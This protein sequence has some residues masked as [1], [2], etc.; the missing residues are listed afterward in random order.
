MSVLVI[1]S[2][3]YLGE[4]VVDELLSQGYDVVGFDLRAAE[5]R[6][7]RE[8]EGYAFERGDMTS[9][10]DVSDAIT[11]H[12]VDAAVQLAYYGTPENGLLDSAEQEPY[13]ASNT[14]VTGFNNV[15]ECARQFDLDALVWASSTVVYGPPSYYDEL[16]IETVDEESPTNPTSLYGA[17]K[18]HNEYV[19]EMYRR[20][21]G[22]D[23]AGIR[24]P[25]IYGPRRYPGAQPFIV[26]MFDTVAEG[27]RIDI[28]DGDTTWDLL[29]ERD[30]GP[31]LASVL[32]AGAYEQS[33]YNVYGHTVTVREL[34]SLALKFAPDDADV[35][36]DDGDAA[37]L[38]APLDDSRFRTEF[39]YRPRYDAESAVEDYLNTIA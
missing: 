19:A 5:D 35:S 22:L 23:V 39:E 15:L 37:V 27:G 3:G 30:V 8:R 11:T 4:Y 26:E 7:R 20:E 32:E 29:Y 9:F 18:V 10:A 12:D 31:L 1:G 2:S 13:T 34:A 21:Y 38:P 36:V 33:V 16:D 25:L 28:E 17:C 6:D 24:L 14:N